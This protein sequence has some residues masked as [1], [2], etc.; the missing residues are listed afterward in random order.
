MEGACREHM[1]VLTEMESTIFSVVFLV[2]YSIYHITS[3][4]GVTG[5]DSGELQA[6]ACVS[7]IFCFLVNR[8]HFKEQ[9]NICEHIVFNFGVLT[10][11]L[12]TAH[13]PGYPLFTLLAHVAAQMPLPRIVFDFTRLDQMIVFDT[14]PTVA[15]KVNHMCCILGKFKYVKSIHVRYLTALLSIAYFIAKTQVQ[16]LLHFFGHPAMNY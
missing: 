5:G 10:Q 6:E 9:F 2:S 16:L 1:P 13:P 4:S 7:E 12:G 11:Q 8:L 3:F 15:W 14:H